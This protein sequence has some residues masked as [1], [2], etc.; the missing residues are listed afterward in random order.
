MRIFGVL[1]V[2]P[3]SFSDG[4][5]WVEPELAVRHALRLHGEGADVIDVGG[6]STRPGASRI[7]E[8]E[9]WRRIGPVIHRLSALRVP[10]SVDTVNAS[11]ARK[12]IDAGVDIVNDVSGGLADTDMAPLVRD[13][14]VGYVVM[15]S[16][17][18]AH[19]ARSYGDV[20]TEVR[21]ALRRRVAALTSAG[22]PADRLI[23]DPGLGFSKDADQNW[24]LLGHIDS[25]TDDGSRVMIGHSRKRFVR[26]IDHVAEDVDGLQDVASAV[27]TGM[28]LE[29]GV[30]AVRVHDVLASSVARS[31]VTRLGSRH[32]AA[33]PFALLD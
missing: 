17:G 13:S 24:A 5:R 22:I 10:M 2:T 20:A 18:A 29:R 9:E 28:M 6:E 15:H 32:R 16:S 25:L 4:G 14:G 12:A 3:D 33:S 1:N 27:L 19:R 30:W 8:E 31:I 23:I 21:D 11:T 7:D 26:S